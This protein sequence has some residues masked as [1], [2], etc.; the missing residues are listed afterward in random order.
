[1]PEVSR[2]ARQAAATRR[3]LVEIARHLW[4]EQ[5]YAAVSIGALLETAGLARGALYHHFADKRELFRAVVE[6]VESEVLAW[7]SGAS[8]VPGGPWA[9]LRWACGLYLSAC[10]DPGVRRILLCD[11]PALLEPEPSGGRRLA[12]LRAR[13]ERALAED[14][15]QAETLAPLLLGALDAAALGFATRAEPGEA[16]QQM[17]T[18]VTLVVEGLRLVHLQGAVPAVPGGFKERDAWEAWRRRAGATPTS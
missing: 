11:A 7:M 2:R 5:G 16:W 4:S 10:A 8:N 17:H 13:L 9:E 15:A 12:A 18:A 14:P 6:S 1:M 3:N